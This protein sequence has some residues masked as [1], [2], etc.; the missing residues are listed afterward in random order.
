[1]KTRNFSSGILIA[2][3]FAACSSN[4]SDSYSEGADSTSAFEGETATDLPGTEAKLVKTAN[5][6]FKV[7]DVY[8]TSRNIS[9]EVRHLG[10]MISNHNIETRLLES[11]EIPLSNDS[12]QVISSYNIEAVM[13]VRVP[14]NRLEEF[15][16]FVASDAS[17]LGNIKLNV[18]DRSLDYLATSLKQK[19]RQKIISKQLDNDTLKTDD[20]LTLAEQNDQIIDRKVNN[21][22]TDA[23]VKYSTI[24]LS[25]NQNTLIKKE[26]I[27]NN[28]ISSYDA[29]VYKRFLDALS[30]GLMYFINIFIGLTHLWAFILL[31]LAIWTGYRYYV[32]K[33][34]IKPATE[35]QAN[36]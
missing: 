31:G 18:D 21:L 34:R 35:T 24:D 6:D 36:L 19:S 13:T 15:V 33:R 2:L 27:A 12:L 7:K 3:I 30:D 4:K 29:P 14:S 9:S 25:F 11:K 10:G 26:T 22:R 5:L 23:S 1:M 17:F 32:K 16:Q 8:R 20:A 28:N